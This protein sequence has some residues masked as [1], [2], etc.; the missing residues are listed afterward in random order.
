[1]MIPRPLAAS[2][3]SCVSHSVFYPLD[4]RK[5]IAQTNISIINND[6]HN[7][8]KGIVPASSGAFITTGIYYSIYEC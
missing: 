6:I 4:T 7:V 8:Y 3:A 5:T 2:I 1:M